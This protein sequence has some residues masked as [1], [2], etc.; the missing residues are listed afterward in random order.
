MLIVCPVKGAK[1]E[2]LSI[3]LDYT[4]H[5]TADVRPG[6]RIQPDKIC[7]EIKVSDE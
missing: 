6:T 7:R 4:P 2:T 1:S 5:R 3:K